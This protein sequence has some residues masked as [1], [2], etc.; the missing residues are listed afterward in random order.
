MQ[1][2]CKMI[3]VLLIILLKPFDDT[4]EMVF[5]IKSKFYFEEVISTRQAI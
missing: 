4:N 1:D 2:I 3:D 5:G